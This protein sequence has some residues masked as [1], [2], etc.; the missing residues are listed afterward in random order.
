MR[1]SVPRGGV[2]GALV[3]SGSSGF[4]PSWRITGESNRGVSELETEGLV[5]VASE[6]EDLA[7]HA[8]WRRPRLSRCGKDAIEIGQGRSMIEPAAMPSRVVRSS[9]LPCPRSS[10]GVTRCHSVSR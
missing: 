3:S 8:C 1:V 9:S 6:I 5:L 10:L 7:S 4:H 2:V